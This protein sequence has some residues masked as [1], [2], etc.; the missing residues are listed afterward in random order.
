MP[1]T[2]GLGLILWIAALAGP[3]TAPTSDSLAGVYDGGQIE[4][5]A[6]LELKP[7]G[8]FRYA[9]SYG[10]LDEVA[11]GTWRADADRVVLTSDPFKAPQIAWSK[12]ARRRRGN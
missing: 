12:R 10:A 5:A 8:R 1:V 3:A 7:D 6:G 4:L 9:L 2:T 11:E